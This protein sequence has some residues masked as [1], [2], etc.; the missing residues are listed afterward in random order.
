MKGKGRS[1]TDGQE[2]TFHSIELRVLGEILS[3]T[4]SQH[5]LDHRGGHSAEPR[6]PDA[7]PLFPEG[8]AGA[9]RGESAAPETCAGTGGIYAA[10]PGGQ[11]DLPGG[12]G[13]Q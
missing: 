6:V 10:V 4:Q 3:K 9:D 7:C 5:I 1:R 13:T 2:E 11:G 8:D 12:R